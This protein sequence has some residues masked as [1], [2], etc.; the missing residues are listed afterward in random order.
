MLRL[1]E[2]AQNQ[3]ANVQRLADR[4][5]GVFVPA[6]IG[7]ALVTLAGW[8]LVGGTNE[9]AFSAALSVLIIACPCALGLATPTALMVASGEGARLGIFFKGYQALEESQEIDTVLLDK[10]GTVTEGA[11]V[12]EDVSSVDGISTRG[13]AGMGR[14]ARAGVGTPRGQGDRP[15]GAE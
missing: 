14:I 11:T 7:I 6:V 13:P 2:D 15:E 1:V 12:V 10:T 4:I 8:L 5:A 9:E 3:K